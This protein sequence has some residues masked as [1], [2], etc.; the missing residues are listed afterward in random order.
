MHDTTA[1][2]QPLTGAKEI[3]GDVSSGGVVVASHTGYDG[4]SRLINESQ[5]DR[6]RS[7]SP[8]EKVSFFTARLR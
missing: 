5:D 3:T 6:Q 7:G 1:L 8:V 4:E 2:S